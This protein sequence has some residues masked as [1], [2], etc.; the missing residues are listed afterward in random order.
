MYILECSDGSYYTGSTTNRERRIAEHQ[1]GKGA[2]FTKR[3]LPVVLRYSENYQLI[4]EA[5]NREKQVQKW[6]RQKKLA[7]IN[8]QFEVLPALSKKKWDN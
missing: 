1:A 2:N 3:R 7:L 4:F 8:K 5:F 6:S